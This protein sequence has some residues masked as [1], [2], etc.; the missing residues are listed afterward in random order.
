MSKNNISVVQSD[1]LSKY[2]DKRYVIVDKE[3]GELLDDAN[4]Y[5]YK[6]MTNICNLTV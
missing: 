5:G 2:D 6:S 4:G 1:A 3:T